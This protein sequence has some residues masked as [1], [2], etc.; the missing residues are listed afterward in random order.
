M[1]VVAPELLVSLA[2]G[3]WRGAA[4][5][6]K[7]FRSSKHQNVRDW[8]WG[9]ASFANMGGLKFE[10]QMGGREIPARAQLSRNGAREV[11]K[12]RQDT[13]MHTSMQDIVALFNR[14]R[15][16]LKQ[17]WQKVAG[18]IAALFR[19]FKQ[20]LW[21]T[22][23]KNKG[24]AQARESEIPPQPGES[25]AAEMDVLGRTG[26]R[27]RSGLS[28]DHGP[29]PSDSQ[30]RSH[31]EQPSTT[32]LPPASAS[33]SVNLGRATAISTDESV[34][35]DN[36]EQDQ[37]DATRLLQNRQTIIL[38]LNAAQIVAA[39]ALGILDEGPRLS[40]DDIE[41]TGKESVIAKSFATLQLV[42]FA[43][44]V[45][46]QLCRGQIT[47]LELATSAYV[48][49]ALFAYAL[50]WSRPQGVERPIEYLVPLSNT[51]RKVTDR[52]LDNLRQFGGSQFLI[53]N[54]VQPFGMDNKLLDPTKPI[55]TDTSIT[56]FA[57]IGSKDEGVILYDDDFAGTIVGMIFGAIYCLGWNHAF[58]SL[59]EK[60]AWRGASVLITGSLIPYSIANGLCTSAFG[61]L[62]G[63]T[64]IV[65]CLVLYTLLGAYISSR[66]FMLVEMVRTLF[67]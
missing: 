62:G 5:G 1:V 58:P 63:K 7:A 2:F 67:I 15:R 54:F 19:L 16:Q 39:Q 14:R 64:H 42:W 49:C 6:L 50:Y 53:S 52:D 38:H 3:S 56:A 27:L 32:Y 51:V 41:D 8:T 55:P 47:Q 45:V 65:H 44:R 61:N 30:H 11:S 4:L 59:W 34:E 9:H 40:K 18:W 37:E 31:R 66:V 33:A 57:F 26:M 46:I 22:S 29:G 36:L 24:K 28:H 10:M 23:N 17:W 43:T 21:R 25:D 35:Q 13:V 20:I 60:W 48:L 12:V